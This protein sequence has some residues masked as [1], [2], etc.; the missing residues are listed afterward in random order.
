MK[1]KL[2]KKLGIVIVF[3][4]LSNYTFSQKSFIET[5]DHQKILVDDSSIEIVMVDEKIV[6]KTPNSNNK[7]TIK[8]KDI[9]SA[10]LGEYD[11]KRMKIA[12]EKKEQLCFTVAESNGKKI[13]GYNK[14]INTANTGA[15]FQ[16]GGA[17]VIKHI[18]Y[19]VDTNGGVI[20]KIEDM[21][22]SGDKYI[23][24][25]K[26]EEDKIRKHFSDCKE[27]MDRLSGGVLKNIDNTKYS[28]F[29]RKMLDRMAA[30]QANIDVF[31]S[32]PTYIN[33]DE[34]KKASS[35]VASPVSIENQKYYFEKTSTNSVGNGTKMTD[36]SMKG[37]IAIEGT[38]FSFLIKKVETKYK[39]LSYENGVM[40]CDDNGNIHTISIE[41]ES[42]NKGNF[43]YDTKITLVTDK[44]MGGSIN[45]YWCKKQ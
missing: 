1:T 4:L 21:I 27:V 23:K 39:I 24:A 30:N 10:M 22:S 9:N 3:L 6:Y 43:A 12:D 37:T 17:T 11:M 18:Y 35:S 26:V 20:E 40:K 19:I 31:F 36:F 38:S 28:K 44:K 32:K 13:V 15:N 2:F 45:Y 7:Q 5:T 14:I 25:M 33:C 16:N 34:P 8:F 41:S 29:E 42:G